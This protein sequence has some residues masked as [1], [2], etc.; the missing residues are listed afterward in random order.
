M[1]HKTECNDSLI[2]YA[3]AVNDA[4][5]IATNPSALNRVSNP[6]PARD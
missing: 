6:T 2:S 4:V 3:T 1:A 5:L